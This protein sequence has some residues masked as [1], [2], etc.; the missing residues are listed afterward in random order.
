MTVTLAA[1]DELIVVDSK[2][3]GDNSL[4]SIFG[5]STETKTSWTITRV[6]Y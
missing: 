2:T 4:V 1:A 5:D 6:N 3:G